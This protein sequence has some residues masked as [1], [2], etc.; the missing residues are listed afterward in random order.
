M[1][2]I[3]EPKRLVYY[4]TYRLAHV[5]TRR[6]AGSRRAAVSVRLSG[7]GGGM[8]ARRRRRGEGMGVLGGEVVTSDEGGCRQARTPLPAAR[9]STPSL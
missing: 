1:H 2:L 6:R 9:Y 3:K 8:Q 4:A 7:G 5:V